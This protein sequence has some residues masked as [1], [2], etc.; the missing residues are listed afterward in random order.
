ML[1]PTTSAELLHKFW[2]DFY[3]ALNFGDLGSVRRLAGLVPPSPPSHNLCS[4]ERTGADIAFA[5]YFAGEL[6]DSESRLTASLVLAEQQG[7]VSTAQWCACALADQRINA[8]DL[9]VAKDWLGVADGLQR[10]L[11]YQ[12]FTAGRLSSWIRIALLEGDAAHAE[13][14]LNS[15]ERDFAAL[16]H[17]RNRAVVAAFRV[18]ISRLRDT[19]VPQLELSILMNA[20]SKARTSVQFDDCVSAIWHAVNANGD[21]TRG[22]RIVVEYMSSRRALHPPITELCTVLKAVEEKL[23]IAG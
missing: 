18:Q 19:E 3:F 7:S 22:D 21:R 17:A 23:P 20:Y 16:R 15:A 14:L 12:H 2:F 13:A 11:N 5:L 6:A 1:S 4:P 8:N 9:K 10:R